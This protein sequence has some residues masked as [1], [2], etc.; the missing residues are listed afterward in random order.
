MQQTTDVEMQKLIRQSLKNLQ[1]QLK[2]VDQRIA[3][4]VACDTANARRIEILD[5]IK[6]LG[7][8]TI[9]TC[10]AEL[11]ELGSLNRRQISNL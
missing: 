3:Q 5:S 11:P 6:G 9:S 2:T 8:V 10:I 4:A 7:T 1:K